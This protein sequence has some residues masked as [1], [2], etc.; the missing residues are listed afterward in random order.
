MTFDEVLAQVRELLEHEGRVAYRILKRRF[1]LTDDDLEDIKADL[2]D[3]KRIAAD[4]EGKVLVWTG[5]APVSGSEF[6]VSGPALLF[7]RLR[8]PNSE[9]PNP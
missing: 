3:A 2:I 4:E 8:T 6:Q 5:A 9:L 1:E 7:R